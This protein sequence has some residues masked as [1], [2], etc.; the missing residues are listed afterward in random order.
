MATLTIRNLNEET[1]A[2]LREIAAKHGHSMEEEARR[3]LNRAVR[4]AEER[5]LGSEIANMFAE[6]GGID[7]QIPPRSLARMLDMFSETES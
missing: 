1:K 6:M 7:L 4:Q 2:K 5:G 3:I